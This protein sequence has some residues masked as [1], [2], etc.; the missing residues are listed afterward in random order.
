MEIGIQKDLSILDTTRLH[1]MIR[2]NNIIKF[3]NKIF[4]YFEIFM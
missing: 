4:N 3:S 2:Y 1:K